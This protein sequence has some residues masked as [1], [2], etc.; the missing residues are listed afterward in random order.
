MHLIFLFW[1]V[2]LQPFLLPLLICLLVLLLLPLSAGHLPPL[3]ILLTPTPFSFRFINSL[4]FFLYLLLL[5]VC[6]PL[7][8]T[9][10]LLL[11]LFI[12]FCFAVILSILFH[13]LFVL[14]AYFFFHAIIL[15]FFL[16]WQFFLLFHSFLPHPHPLLFYLLFASFISLLL[17]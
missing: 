11:S 8:R 9:L 5:R 6:I 1:Q 7:I 16:F 17:V 3:H 2:P 12:N 14:F 4:V 15:F 10:F 13:F